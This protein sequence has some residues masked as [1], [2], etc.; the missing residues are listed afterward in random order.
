MGA[1]VIAKLSVTNLADK[2]GLFEERWTPKVVAASNGQ[3]VKVAKFE[4]EFIWHSHADEDELF[5][6]TK[7]SIDIWL[8]ENGN[9]HRVTLREGE[10]FTRRRAFRSS[11]RR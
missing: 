2:F 4:G 5:L 1:L 6:V 8:R 7:G 3:L 9:E 11:Q 10:L